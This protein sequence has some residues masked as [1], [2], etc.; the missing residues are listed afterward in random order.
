MDTLL[1]VDMLPTYG[2]LCYLLIGMCV[3]LAFR[4]LAHAGGKRR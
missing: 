3:T 4:G 2:L 1:I